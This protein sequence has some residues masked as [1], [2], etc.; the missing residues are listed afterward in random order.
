[1]PPKVDLVSRV[2]RGK[3]LE[4]SQCDSAGVDLLEHLAYRL[5]R[6]VSPEFDDRELVGVEAPDDLGTEGIPEPDL[7]SVVV[8][9]LLE[10]HR[11]VIGIENF[12]ERKHVCR[13]LP[14]GRRIVLHRLT[15]EVA[16]HT[17]GR[18]QADPLPA[19]TLS[20]QTHPHH[21]I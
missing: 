11:P 5:P 15:P 7:V 12:A 1:M 6:S 18:P 13:I 21:Y 19:I 8:P 4:D 16:L 10:T 9:V 3:Q 20:V 14:L 2:G 17:L